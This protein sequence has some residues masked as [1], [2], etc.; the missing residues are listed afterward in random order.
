MKKTNARKR[1]KHPA[2]N[3][4]YNLKTRTELIDYDYI[5]KL[6]EKEKAWLNAFTEEYTNANMNHK[7][8]K[9]HKSKAMKKDCYNRNNARNRDILTRA[10]ASGQIHYLEDILNESDLNEKLRE[11][12]GIVEEGNEGNNNG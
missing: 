8:K 4:K 2:L 12:L 3:P 10:K 7:G 5:D 6:S 11:G 1:A 9:L